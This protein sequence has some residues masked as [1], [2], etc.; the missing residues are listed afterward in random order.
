M[1]QKIKNA[2]HLAMIN[3]D[4]VARSTLRLVTAVIKDADIAARSLD[5]NEG[6]SDEKIIELLE[7]M[8][9]QRKKSEAIYR[10]HNQKERAERELAETDVI[11]SFL[12]KKMSRDAT[13]E[14]VEFVIEDLKINSPSAI[15][16][17]INTM[18]KL[19]PNRLDMGL[20]SGIVKSVLKDRFSTNT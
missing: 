3:N 20:V 10:S 18:K 11:A 8:I 16:E 17:V 14:A 12:P 2:L 19:Y 1:R 4:E 6:L 5:T 15:G 13:R 7:T 9:K